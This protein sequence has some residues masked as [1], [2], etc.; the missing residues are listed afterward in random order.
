MTIKEL[1]ELLSQYDEDEKV[2]FHHKL[3]GKIMPEEITVPI[4]KAEYT[5][6]GIVLT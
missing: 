1:I 6:D 3:K 2:W 5:A 4:K